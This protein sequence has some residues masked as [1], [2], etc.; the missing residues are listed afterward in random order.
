M[1]TFR[2]GAKKNKIFVSPRAL[3]SAELCAAHNFTCERMLSAA[4]ILLARALVS[5]THVSGALSAAQ[6]F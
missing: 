5:G 1:N 6:T 3:V 4:H 2:Y